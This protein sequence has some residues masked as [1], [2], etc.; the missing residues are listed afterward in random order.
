MLLYLSALLLILGWLSTEHFPPWISW[1]AEV[2]VFMAVVLL[3]ARGLWLTRRGSGESAALDVPALGLGLLGLLALIGVQALSGQIQYAGDAL[4]LGLYVGLCLA[5]VTLGFASAG[6]GV[7]S[8]GFAHQ[9]EPLL[10]MASA[11]LAGAFLSSI[12]AWVQVLDVWET[13]AWI[14]R[15]PQLR[16][17]GGNLSQ[18]NHLATLLLM[19]LA[20]LVYLWE[21]KKLGCSSAGLMFGVIASGVILT[22]SRTGMLSLVALLVWWL[23]GKWRVGFSLE[24]KV[25]LTLTALVFLA[26]WLWPQIM[27]R[28]EVSTP[29]AQVDTS[30]G[31]RLV[32]WPQLWQ[33]VLIHPWMGWGLREVSAAH[34]AVAHAYPKAE[35]FTYSHNILLDMALGMGLPLTMLA[36]LGVGY[37]LWKRLPAVR[38]LNAWY[39]LAAVLPLAVHSMLELP[40]AYAYFLAPLM[41]LLGRAEAEVGRHAA[42]QIKRRWANAALMIALV[43]GAGTVVEYFKIEE[44]YRV[45]RF[46]SLRMGSTQA[47]YERPQLHLLTQMDALLR[48]A[49]IAPAP[50]MNGGDLDLLRK[51]ALRHPGPATLNR[52][53]LALVLNG[54]PDEAIRQM[55]VIRTV[56]GEKT[57]G[58]IKTKWEELAL[59]SYP[60]LNQLKLP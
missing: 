17:P 56:L 9:P 58:T 39:A 51:V 11:L 3:S 19:G 12:V 38:S 49:R 30:G 43:L 36:I 33:A 34:N 7:S 52:Y 10:L 31:M 45:I 29:G 44:D 57:Y 26:F 41:F 21:N 14:V 47:G 59:N 54:N 8:K 48:G 55:R 13:S 2:M 5:A 20:S 53:A 60:E 4:V 32:V 18:P 37:W 46:E 28:M 50:N 42:W 27:W 25:V 22:E 15:M 35:L 1:H 23:V 24:F 6:R 40:F 16:R